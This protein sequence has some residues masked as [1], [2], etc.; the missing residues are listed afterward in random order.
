MQTP[1]HVAIIMDGNRR[2][3]KKNKLM[4]LQG[5]KRGA[6][7]IKEVMGWFKELSVN[8][9]TLYTFSIENFNRKKEEVE[10]LMKLFLKKFDELNNDK[11]IHENKIRINVIGRTELFPKKVQ[12]RI[13]HIM[14]KTKDY[15]DYTIN[16]A[17]GYG[18][19]SEIADAAKQIAKDIKDGNV[20]V[21]DID[22]EMVFDNLYLN[23]EPDIIIRTGGDFRISNFL[24]FQGVYSELFFLEKLW[25]EIE[26]QDLVN[27]INEFKER[28]RRFGK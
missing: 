11:S 10:Y 14:D 5:H 17:M 2:Y 22:E 19:R 6:D 13:K 3:A 21:E 9:L 12:E 4:T 27:C 15:N 1:K 20:D 8:E 7:K 16:F 24:P 18:G 26:K 28:E 23:S 25:P